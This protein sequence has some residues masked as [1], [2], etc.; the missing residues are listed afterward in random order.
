MSTM[1]KQNNLDQEFWENRYRTKETGWDLGAISPAIKS[2]IN[3]LKNKDLNILIPGG[4]HNYEAEYLWCSGFKNIHIVDISEVAL[5]QF[6][7]RVPDFPTQQIIQLD[8]FN[9]TDTFDLIIEQTFFCA[10]DPNLRTSYSKKMNQ[11]LKTKGRLVGLLFDFELT[12][13]GPPFGGDLSEYNTLFSKHFTIKTL[14]TAIN[15]V[16]PRQNKELFFIF[17]KTS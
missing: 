2:Y 7:Q 8:F 3:Q 5:M 15:S 17:E 13:V 16:K 1:T 4:G 9:L 6:Q 12:K 10:L 11:L 14:E